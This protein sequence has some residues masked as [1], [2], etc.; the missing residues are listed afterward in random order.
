MEQPHRFH[1]EIDR[2]RAADGAQSLQ[3]V[4][5][6]QCHRMSPRSIYFRAAVASISTSQPGSTRPETSIVDRAGFN[7]CAGG[8][9][10]LAKCG[11]HA[12][13]IHPLC[14]RRRDQE[15]AHH[16]DVAKPQPVLL[17]LRLDLAQHRPGLGRGV[18]EPRDASR[19]RGRIDRLGNLAADIDDAAVRGDLDRAR[20]RRIRRAHPL[21]RLRLGGRRKHQHSRKPKQCAASPLSPVRRQDLPRPLA[22]RQR[23]R[24]SVRALA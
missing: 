20:D 18:A 4:A 7:G 19:R 24:K 14:A 23:L 21:D 17:Q 5:P 12:R 11:H 1:A 6:S 3:K 16:D 10:F 13:E 2:A 15:H 8:A 22:P 9:E